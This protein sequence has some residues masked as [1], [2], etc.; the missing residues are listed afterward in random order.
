MKVQLELNFYLNDIMYLARDEANQPI[1]HDF[2]EGTVLPKSATIF[3]EVPIPQTRLVKK[4]PDTL[5]EMTK[6]VAVP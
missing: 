4:Q 1:T 6:M 5:A 2:P 3:D